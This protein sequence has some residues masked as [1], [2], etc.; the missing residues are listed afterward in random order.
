MPSDEQ[1][2]QHRDDAVKAWQIKFQDNIDKRVGGPEWREPAPKK[3]ERA[4]KWPCSVCDRQCK[5][6][7]TLA[8][9]MKSHE[10]ER[11]DRKKK[12]IKA[13]RRSSSDSDNEKR[14][15]CMHCGKTFDARGI[16]KHMQSHFLHIK[17]DQPS[18]PNTTDFM[19][20]IA[21]LTEQQ[22]ASS[23]ESQKDL[24]HTLKAAEKQRSREREQQGETAK[25]NAR[26]LFL[27]A[28]QLANGLGARHSK[29]DP[30]PDCNS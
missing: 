4:R 3:K 29:R 15:A 6:E 1:R 23:P 14:V 17:A 19:Q 8:T 21:L 18:M 30:D 11:N 2:Q 7:E 26:H 22:K 25:E 12:K 13:R 16:S 9:H 5:T 27:L 24:P 28:S 10:D 20:V